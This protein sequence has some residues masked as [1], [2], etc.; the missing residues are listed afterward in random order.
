MERVFIAAALRRHA[1]NRSRAAKEL[2]IHRSTL[3]RKMKALG[4]REPMS[5]A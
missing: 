5:G 3:R 2:G 4:V 1:W